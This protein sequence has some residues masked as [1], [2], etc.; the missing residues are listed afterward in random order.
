MAFTGSVYGNGTTTATSGANVRT[1]FYDRAGIKASVDELV[2]GKWTDSKSM[3]KKSGKTFKISRF[4]HILDD[5]NVNDQGLDADGN[6]IGNTSFIFNG[7]AY[8][9][10]GAADTAKATFDA[11]AEGIAAIANGVE[12][13]VIDVTNGGGNAYG[14]SR[15]IGNV[16]SGMPSLAEGADRVNRVGVTKETFETTQKRYGNFIEY[17]D[18]VTMFSED[19]I[20]V[21]YREKL[22]RMAGETYDDVVQIG[23]LGANGVSMFTGTATDI[24]EIG[25]GDEDARINKTVV[26]KVAKRLKIN[27]AE[28]NTSMLSGSVKVGTTPVN[29]SFYAICGPDVKYDLEDVADFKAVHEYGYA[30]NVPMDEV[31]SLHETRFLETNRMMKYEGGGAAE[32]S[33]NGMQSTGGNYDVFPILYPTKGSY[34]SVGLQGEGKI[35]FKAKAPGTP[36]TE[37]PYGVKGLFSY[38]FWYAGLA[39]Q[40]E[41]LAV[42][43]V[44]ASA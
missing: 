2:F 36:T 42:I 1:D 28:K 8:G 34:A 44:G 20:Q 41:K 10:S 37:D 16:A 35:K 14:S 18:E 26:R 31:G 11:T 24:D 9:T 43:Y 22:G 40:P 17:T 33:N 25:T 5:L 12:P 32:T 15:D 7:V 19:D 38:N 13:T 27:K 6:V 23:M 3:P 21:E 30:S 29:R 39:L 4:R